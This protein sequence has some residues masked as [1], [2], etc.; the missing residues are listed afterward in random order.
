[1]FK[2]SHASDITII[3]NGIFHTSSKIYAAI[4]DAFIL[5]KHDLKAT[6]Q[7]GSFFFGHG[8]NIGS[9]IAAFK[10]VYLLNCEWVL[11]DTKF[12]VEKEIFNNIH[13]INLSC[14]IYGLTEVC[15]GLLNNTAR[16]TNINNIEETSLFVY[17]H[18]LSDQ[19]AD[20]IGRLISNKMTYGVMLIISKSNIQG[21]INMVTLSNKL[22]KLEILNLIGNVRIMC[23]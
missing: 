15:I 16:D 23:N 11:N 4:E 14:S 7:F 20:I 22:S 9:N 6:L 10:N 8:I 12:I 1:L 19:V 17:N 2:S 5:Y 3:D 13:L 21:I 18:V